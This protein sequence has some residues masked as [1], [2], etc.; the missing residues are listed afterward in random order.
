VRFDA[1]YVRFMGNPQICLLKKRR[2]ISG[3]EMVVNKFRA[4]KKRMRDD[5]RGFARSPLC[6]GT[7][8]GE[9]VGIGRQRAVAPPGLFLAALAPTAIMGAV[10]MLL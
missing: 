4:V 1:W 5:D 9:S 8:E 2:N 3:W 10:F 6:C 7:N